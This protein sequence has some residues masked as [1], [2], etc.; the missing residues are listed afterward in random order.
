MGDSQY[1]A[2]NS[3]F[4]EHEYSCIADLQPPT[5]ASFSQAGCAVEDGEQVDGELDGS[6][7]GLHG[8][9]QPQLCRPMVECGAQQ[10]R[11]MMRQRSAM[12]LVDHPPQNLT[13]TFGSVVTLADTATVSVRGLA[14]P[15]PRSNVALPPA[16]KQHVG[17]RVHTGISSF[18]PVPGYFDALGN[19]GSH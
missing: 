14:P 4:V 19:S 13:T 2:C 5:G 8:T 11:Q 18:H 12:Q 6:G 15:P 10:C 17:A 1:N 9:G 7:Q 16:A 3:R